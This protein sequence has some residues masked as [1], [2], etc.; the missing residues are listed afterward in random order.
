MDEADKMMYEDKAKKKAARNSLAETIK[1]P[2][3]SE[4]EEIK[5]EPA[6]DIQTEPT[7]EKK[8]GG[9]RN[10]ETDLAPEPEV[11]SE[12]ETIPQ[13]IKVEQKEIVPES[14]VSEEPEEPKEKLPYG[15]KLE[16]T[17]VKETETEKFLSTMWFVKHQ[18]TCQNKNTVLGLNLK[19]FEI[20][21]YP[22]EKPD[23]EHPRLPVKIMAVISNLSEKRNVVIFP[24]EQGRK[25]LIGAYD[26]YIFGITGSFSEKGFNAKIH[27]S[28]ESEYD[29]AT[30][31][32]QYLVQQGEYLPENFA[33][34]V[35]VGADVIEFYPLY[36]ENDPDLGVVP[37]VYRHFTG[38]N[39][40]DVE[41]EITPGDSVFTDR[42]GNNQQVLIFWTPDG[43]LSA[44][45]V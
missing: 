17:A 41:I 40:D 33:K 8:A 5:S 12:T 1:E 13:D 44:N 3:V 16:T 4:K 21:V 7:H 23:F 24:T 29:I 15:L 42:N 45:V 39:E 30:D 19:E 11:Q 37:C 14:V 32:D 36:K 18:I 25:S 22:L 35:T 38:E 10:K 2:V 31:D 28:G 43:K 20:T 9:W 6:P 26:D 34:T 27:L